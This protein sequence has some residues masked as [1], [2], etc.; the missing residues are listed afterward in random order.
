MKIRQRLGPRSSCSR[1][2]PPFK[3]RDST[4]TLRSQDE[5]LTSEVYLSKIEV[6]GSEDE[7]RY[8]ENCSKLP[9]M[10]DTE[11]KANRTISTCFVKPA[12]DE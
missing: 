10:T 12:T 4:E 11:A 3:L 6:T 9:E 5:Q 7:A 8:L 2:V 1:K